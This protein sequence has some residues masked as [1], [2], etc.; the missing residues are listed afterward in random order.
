MP[1]HILRAKNVYVAC[2]NRDD[3]PYIISQAGDECLLIGTDYG[4]T[5]T[6]SDV[7]AIAQFRQ[8]TDISE[9]SK[10]KII[11]DNPRRLYGLRSI[12]R[13]L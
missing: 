5:D 1:Q 6:S 2:Q 7:D 12:Y 3:V 9:D 4:H 13:R 8:R 10:H 11:S